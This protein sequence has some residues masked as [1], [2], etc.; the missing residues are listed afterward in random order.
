MDTLFA[1]FERDLLHTEACKKIEMGIG[2]STLK[3][4]QTIRSR[5]SHK[6]LRIKKAAS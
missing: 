4:T 6:I 1:Q 3:E 5:T 2:S